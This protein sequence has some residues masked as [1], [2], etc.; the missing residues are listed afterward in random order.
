ME[1]RRSIE[2]LESKES[3]CKQNQKLIARLNHQNELVLNAAG[4]GI[5]GLSIHGNHTFVNPAAAQ[6]LGYT[7]DE[8]T[9]GHSHAIWHYKKA[10]G[11]PYPVE[12]CPI[13]AAY[14][15]GAVHRKSDEVFR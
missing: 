8:L 5:F 9:G 2:V 6:M 10:D 3:E 15:D 1:L 14:K 4:E 7:V 12:E 11:S 13:Y